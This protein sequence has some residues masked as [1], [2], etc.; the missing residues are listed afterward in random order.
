MKQ[1]TKYQGYLLNP[2]ITFLNHGSYGAVPL[3][4]FEVYQ[5][6]QRE[7]E[8]QPVLF[9]GRKSGQ[10]LAEA[11]KVLAEYLHCQPEEVVYVTNST[12]GVNA[13]ARSLHLK[14]GDEVLASNQEYGATNRTW[15]FLAQKEGFL[16]K[17]Q[18]ISTPFT[19]QEALIEEF[20]A[21]VNEHTRVIFL[22]HITSDTAAIFPVEEICRRARAA[23]ILTLIDGAHAP[24]QLELD[25][26]Q[27]GCDFYTGNLHKWVNAPKGAAFLYAHPAVQALIEPLVVSFG[28]QSVQP[29]PSPLVD[30]HEYIGTRE[31][32]A[33]LSVPAAIAYQNERNWPFVRQT[34]HEMVS[35][36]LADIQ[37]ITG[38]PSLYRNDS[39]YSQLAAFALPNTWDA[40]QTKTTLY[41]T[42]QIELPVYL[43][44]RQL[45]GRISI[46]EYNPWQD[47]QNLLAALSDLKTKDRRAA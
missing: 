45:F 40:A 42:F 13:V 7:L 39:W 14:N 37:E 47:V 26:T 43:W 18:P 28:W 11:R 44:N 29:G 20:W 41:D 32:A 2:E 46:Q 17:V 38:L 19:T 21:G 36:A 5:E 24:G 34:C 27:M 23:G 8:R 12:Y 9:I 1:T 35:R 31:L 3:S 22:S 25:L 15:Q 6:W 30:Y 16:Y 10:L 4:V 33:F